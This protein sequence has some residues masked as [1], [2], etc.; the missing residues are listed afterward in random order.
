MRR[1]LLGT[2]ALS[3]IALATP[4]WAVLEIYTD[5]GGVINLCV[6]NAAC[7]TNPTTGVITLAPTTINGVVINGEIATSTSPGTPD[8]LNN[9]VLSVIN[10]NPFPISIDVIVSDTGFKGPVSTFE[11]AG[12]GTWQGTIGSTIT[13]NWFVDPANTQGA[14]GGTTPGTMVATFTNTAT[15]L[16]DSFSNGNATGPFSTSGPFS[17]TIQSEYDLQPFGQLINRGISEEL[18]VP[19]P[20]TWAMVLLGFAGLGYAAFRR[21]AKTRVIAEAI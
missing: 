20:S 7:D 10:T 3:A 2:A 8:I 21:G 5:N 13:M 19:E 17:M 14:V 18:T 11:A 15:T 6:D 16:L 1:I 9:S 4:A 12:A